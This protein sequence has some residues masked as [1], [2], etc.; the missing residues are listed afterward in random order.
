MISF[1]NRLCDILEVKSHGSL[2]TAISA[3]LLASQYEQ[4]TLRLKTL[5]SIIVNLEELK[6]QPPRAAAFSSQNR[7][8]V[9]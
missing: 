5:T 4:K 3:V 8:N 7:R 1:S 2:L 9:L 6:N